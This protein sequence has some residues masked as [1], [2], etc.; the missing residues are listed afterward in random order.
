MMKKAKNYYL[1]ENNIKNILS[2]KN[3]K[4]FSLFKI[5]CLIFQKFNIKMKGSIRT[6]QYLN[7]EKTG[8]IK[9]YNSDG[10]LIFEGELLEGKKMG[11]TKNI[12]KILEKY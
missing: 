9:E 7:G 3:K 11:I 6:L 8:K 4:F 1:M 5:L 10:I 12:T 2:P